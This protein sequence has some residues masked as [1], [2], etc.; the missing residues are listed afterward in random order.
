MISPF[1]AF[2]NKFLLQ[3]TAYQ[4]VN[5]LAV[6]LR[7][8][9]DTGVVIPLSMS[10][11]AV[12]NVVL[13][14]GNVVVYCMWLC[15]RPSAKLTSLMIRGVRRFIKRITG[16]D[17]A[18]YTRDQSCIMDSTYKYTV[19]IA[20]FVLNGMMMLVTFLIV[21]TMMFTLLLT[22]F[23]P[24][25]LIVTVVITLLIALSL[26]AVIS[27]M[28]KTLSCALS[29]IKKT[30]GIILLTSTGGIFMVLVSIMSCVVVLCWIF[31]ISSMQIICFALSAFMILS[32]F[33]TILILTI[34]GKAME[35]NVEEAQTD[36]AKLSLTFSKT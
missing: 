12:E 29:T 28:I 16:V 3:F 23:V 21:L 32:L 31:I 11:A 6:Q 7:T 27:Q 24:V 5:A 10:S 18:Q 2:V 22:P 1:L 26:I 20:T 4:H 17:P 25:V 15:L 33:A 30:V 34:F 36:K 13:T 14:I 8:M 19:N 35:T 9:S